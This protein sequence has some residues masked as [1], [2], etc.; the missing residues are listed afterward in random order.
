MMFYAI[1]S[2][3]D[4]MNSTEMNAKIVER[5]GSM[6]V[7]LQNSEIFDLQ[8]NLVHSQLVSDI[9]GL[10]HEWR[11]LFPLDSCSHLEAQ[12]QATRR[13]QNARLRL[14]VLNMIIS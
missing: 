3:L 1:D 9:P 14:S 7:A 8:I 2:L 6:N 11:E 10:A 12:R 13:V 4:G 5:V